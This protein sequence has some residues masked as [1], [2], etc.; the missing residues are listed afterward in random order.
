MKTLKEFVDEVSQNIPQ[1]IKGHGFSLVEKLVELEHIQ[2]WM[3]T[4]YGVEL[5]I[6]VKPVEIKEGRNYGVSTVER[7]LKN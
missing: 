1:F 7:L 5:E 4:M 2:T 6:T 3:N